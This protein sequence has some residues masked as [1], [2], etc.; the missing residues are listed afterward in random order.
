MFAVVLEDGQRVGIIGYWQRTWHDELVYETGSS[1][2]L[3]FHG[4]WKLLS[5]LLS[6][7]G[8]FASRIGR[9]GLQTIAFRSEGPPLLV[10]TMALSGPHEGGS[11]VVQAKR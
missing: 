11:A 4:W 2:M 3:A 8:P 5:W 1:V 6:L 9:G 10:R 7:I